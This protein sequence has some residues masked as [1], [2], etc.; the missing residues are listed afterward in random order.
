MRKVNKHLSQERLKEI[1]SYDPD[2]GVFHWLLQKG[3]RVKA[4]DVAGAP[5]TPERPYVKIQIDGFKWNGHRLAWLYVYGEHPEDVIDHINGDPSDNW[6][7]NLRSVTQSVNKI[8][9]RRQ[10]NAKSKYVGVYFYSCGGFEGWRGK[11]QRKQSPVYKTQ[12]EAHEFYLAELRKFN[13]SDPV[14]QNASYSY[15]GAQP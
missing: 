12:E 13:E 7:C 6:I 15:L 14:P 2:T 3:N 11:F 9:S 8:N 4:G 10:K 1:L 5:Y